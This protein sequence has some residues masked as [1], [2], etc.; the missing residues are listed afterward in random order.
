MA[1][2]EFTSGDIAAAEKPSA[3]APPAPASQA[4]SATADASTTASPN[5]P[6]PK[7]D[8][9]GPVPWERHEAILNNTRRDLESKLHGLS[10][11]ERLDRDRVEKALRLADLAERDPDRLVQQF[12]RPAQG[13]PPTP[14]ARD[15]KGEAF[16]SADQAAALVSH[17]VKQ[18]VD[19]VRDEL[20]QRLSP[21]ESERAQSRQMDSLHTQIQAA[22]SWPGFGDHIADI[23]AAIADAN[24][25]RERLSLHDAYIKI[26]VPK[27]AASK[28]QLLADEKKKWLAELN[29]TSVRAKDDLNPQ[30]L[31]AASRKADK[32]KSF[33][34]LIPEVTEEL[35]RGA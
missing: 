20:G 5:A 27:L 2:T 17:Y 31:P 25:K 10:W 23:T 28:D 18:A 9:Y 13:Q 30:R 15:D 34:E 35:R 24:A 11:A 6:E 26:V 33:R 29:N 12:S 21:I 3:A 1:D 22:S 16:Y 7:K 8:D 4:A 14:N 19:A 32:D